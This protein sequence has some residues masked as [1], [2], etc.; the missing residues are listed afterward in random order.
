M[1]GATILTPTTSGQSGIASGSDLVSQIARIVGGESEDNVRAQALD[2]LNR[3]RTE[4]NQ[5]D[6]WFMKTTQSPITLSS[7]TRTYSLASAFHKPSYAR[8]I[9]SAALPYR[10]LRYEDD[11]VFVRLEPTQATQGLP[12]HYSLRN[13]FDDGHISLYPIPD[14]ATAT[15]FRLSV[16]YFARMG[17]FSD[18]GSVVR[19]PEEATNLLV[20]GG[21]A[22]I[23]RE[24]L[25]DS[26]VTI[27]AFQDFQRLM[28]LLI[29]Q[30]RRI[31][32]ANPRFRIRRPRAAVDT[33]LYIR[34]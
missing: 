21:Q 32:D 2:C 34:M 15:D 14:T 26:P 24:R 33:T 6:W 10:E 22:Y 18:S 23:L 9:D 12:G 19:I 4:M 1:P 20:V 30:D 13:D 8:L 27:Q 25:K 11:A 5:H 3:V 16:E 17:A 29:V 31:E 7:G 28:R